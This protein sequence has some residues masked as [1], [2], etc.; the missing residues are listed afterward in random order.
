MH[1]Q[2]RMQLGVGERGKTCEVD[3][4]RL[5][6]IDEGEGPILLCTHAVGHG[7]SD[8]NALRKR[9]SGYR[10]IALDWPGHGNSA[11]DHKETSPWRYA[12]LME[13]FIEKLSLQQP[14][15]LGNSIGGAASIEYTAKHP[16]KVKGLILCDPGGIHKRGWFERLGIAMMVKF[17]AWGARGGFGFK[18]MFSMYYRQV[19]QTKAAQKQRELIVS[20]A[21]EQA[22]L[23]KEAWASFGQEKADLRKVVQQITCPVWCAWSKRDLS[24]PLSKS[25]PA[26]K[27]FPNVEISTFRGGHSAF[28]EVPDAF[29]EKLQGFLDKCEL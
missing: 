4:V 5:V 7:A 16:D 27:Q 18:S 25:L 22:P 6:Y 2:K 19:L 24:I 17:F 8:F 14:F 11:R 23:L 29:A 12:E 20:T 9:L 28:L 1:T 10:V 13:G 26:I 21:L 3:G 15:L